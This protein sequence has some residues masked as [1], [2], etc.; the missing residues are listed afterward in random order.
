MGN[1]LSAI[2]DGALDSIKSPL[3]VVKDI[4]K[5]DFSGAFKNLKHIPGN[6]ERANKEIL[7][8]A[9]IR[10]WVGDHPGE[11]AA[12]IV[13]S[14]FGGAALM[15]GGA[16]AAGGAGAAGAGGAAGGSAALGGAG[17][18]GYLAP[19]AAGGVGATGAGGS[20][21]S[22]GALSAISSQA[23]STAALLQMGNAGVGASTATAGASSFT[24]AM[25]TTQGAAASGG[26][27][28]AASAPAI[29]LQTPAAGGASAGSSTMS[30]PE[31]WNQIS[32][33]VNSVKK[34]EQ[35]DQTL[36]PVPMG[37]GHRGNFNFDRKNF[38]NQALTQTYGE[39]YNKPTKTPNIKF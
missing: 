33:L 34:P 29:A 37:S 35:E 4:G 36:A 28:G 30:N 16:A 8:S 2:T 22:T 27:Y 17:A 9:G 3:K 14:I 25:L 19:T 39:L 10:G 7:Q 15:G 18:A 32:K 6:Q 26:T 21:A 1:I 31:T 24:P 23:P 5:G 13:G 12:A 38:Q 20:L 11:S